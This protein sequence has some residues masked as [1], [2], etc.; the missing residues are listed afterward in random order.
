M[1]GHTT[2]LVSS[3]L[4]GRHGV[5]RD[6][7]KTVILTTHNHKIM[8]LA[9]NM[10]V[11]EARHII[12]TDSPTTLL[13]GDGYISK[14]G[15]EANYDEAEQTSRTPD[16]L[17]AVESTWASKDRE[18][19][20]TT[21]LT[22]LRRKNGCLS[23]Y[24]YCIANAGYSSVTLHV[25]FIILWVF[26]TE[27][28]PVVVKWWSEANAI[29]PNQDMRMWLGVYAILGVLGTLGA[30]AAAWF[31]LVSII[32]Y[33]GIHLHSDP[34]QQPSYLQSCIQ[35]WLNFM[36]DLLVTVLAIVVVGTTVTWH[37]RSSAGS[38]AQTSV[39]SWSSISAKR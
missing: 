34:L 37:D 28:S 6:Q 33:T 18:G 23:V 19:E 30:T 32:S 38:V 24:K 31:A 10:I 26:S 8:A 1:D 7:H 22:D 15:F 12:E 39:L 20:S 21:A 11:L 27:F 2:D 25:V 14:L 9:N 29:K 17:L 35:H 16:S 36:L 4:H 5:L 3:R 13:K